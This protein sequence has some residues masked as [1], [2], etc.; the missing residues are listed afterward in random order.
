MSAPHWRAAEANVNAPAPVR[1]S[2]GNP[3]RRHWL[4]GAFVVSLM[5]AITFTGLQVYRA[6]QRLHEVR[7]TRAGIEAEL[8]EARL[9]NER[10]QQTLE[11]VRSDEYMELTAK[12]MGFT[13]P[14]EKVY[15][16]GSTKGD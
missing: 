9:K 13:K 16:T 7:E 3:L 5:G 4:T 2:R 1:R 10:L 11:K 12:K 14:N 8:K 6:D 15:Q